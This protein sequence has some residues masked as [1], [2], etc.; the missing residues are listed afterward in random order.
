MK[1]FNERLGYLM[2]TICNKNIPNH[3]IV[4]D[5]QVLL[6]VF[7]DNNCYNSKTFDFKIGDSNKLEKAIVDLEDFLMKDKYIIEFKNRIFDLCEVFD[8]EEEAKE[9]CY[10]IN[11][12]FELDLKWRKESARV[13]KD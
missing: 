11:T 1:N 13:K 3:V 12:K 4:S 10:Q 5:N 7:E 8:T 6:T 2:A 9:Y